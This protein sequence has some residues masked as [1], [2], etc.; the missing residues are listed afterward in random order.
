[1]SPA[2]WIEVIDGPSEPRHLIAER[3]KGEDIE[4][5]DAKGNPYDAERECQA[6]H[7][8]RSLNLT[9]ARRGPTA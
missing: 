2:A 9:Q 8:A 3:I 4:E 6:E 5:S 1:M 7:G